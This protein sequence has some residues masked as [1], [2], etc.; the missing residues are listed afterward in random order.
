MEHVINSFSFKSSRLY[1]FS[2]LYQKNLFDKVFEN[3]EGVSKDDISTIKEL[4]KELNINDL[5]LENGPQLIINTTSLNDGSLIAYS[6]KGIKIYT[7]EENK[8]QPFKYDKLPQK[9]IVK[10]SELVAAST[11]VPFIFD[12]LLMVKTNTR[13]VYSVD[14][15]V[16]DNLGVVTLLNEKCNKF[17][18]SDG[19]LAIDNRKYPNNRKFNVLRRSN[20]ILMERVKQM[21]LELIN[22]KSIERYH[23]REGLKRDRSF[24]DEDKTVD[25]NNLLLDYISRIRTNL[26]RFSEVEIKVLTTR[27]LTLAQG[28]KETWDFYIDLEKLERDKDKIDKLK[29]SSNTLEFQRNALWN[30]INKNQLHSYI[31]IM[32]IYA[33]LLISSIIFLPTY[34]ELTGILVSTIILFLLILFNQLYNFGILIPLLKSIFRLLFTKKYIITLAVIIILL[35]KYS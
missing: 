19:S 16:F 2:K 30:F 12:P 3:M 18:I 5:F 24:L 31:V 21:Q 20:D 28:D 7:D 35:F 9:S 10:L 26:D 25:D 27:G 11:G 4:K 23:L 34:L 17:I 8:L 32:T 29:Y 14:G 15:G 22:E 13:E 1:R 6:T 33:S